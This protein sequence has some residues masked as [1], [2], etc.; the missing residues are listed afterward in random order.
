MINSSIEENRADD[1]KIE[2]IANILLSWQGM[3][4]LDEFSGF[5][6]IRQS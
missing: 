5:R 2:E 1:T 6:L 4:P 3:A